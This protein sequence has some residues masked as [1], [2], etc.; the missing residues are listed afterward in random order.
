MG[1]GT[2]PQNFLFQFDTGSGTLW[3]PTIQSLGFGFNTQASSTFYQ[4]STYGAIV[5]GD[6]SHVSGYMGTDIVTLPGTPIKVTNQ[7]M[8]VNS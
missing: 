6:G 5:Y 4:S 3:I 8:F 7:I 1:I 2:P